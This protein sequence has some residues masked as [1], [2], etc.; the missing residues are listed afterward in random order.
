[1]GKTT[2]STLKEKKAR[3]EKITMITAYDYPSARMADEAG[4]DIV[5]VGDSLGMAVLGYETT[6]PVTMDEMIHHTKAVA[7]GAQNA[8][9]VGDMPFLSYHLS[10][11]KAVANAGRFVQEAR[12]QAVKLEGGEERLDVTRA[13]VSTGIPVL[14][15]IGLTPQSIHQMGGFKV[16]GK[17]K[18]QAGKLMRDAKLLEEAG[19]FALVLECVPAPL[20]K[21]ISESLTIPTI[22]I[23]GGPHCDGQVLVWH[24]LLGITQNLKPR[25]VKNYANLYPVIVEALRNYKTEVEQGK[26]PQKEHSFAM[27]EENIP[28]LY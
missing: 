14:G 25:F 19:I 24:D 5:L 26:F 11:D 3:G 4:I 7:R 16:Q 6:L 17:D 21:V 15:H 8:L 22:G 20:A 28:K 23:G 10:I 18:E 1:M 12:A 2:V 13:I 9:V 27:N